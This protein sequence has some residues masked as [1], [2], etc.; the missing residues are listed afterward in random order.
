MDACSERPHRKS[1]ILKNMDDIA[2]KGLSN[3]SAL[4]F[5]G[6]WVGKIAYVQVVP[7]AASIKGSFTR[8][9]IFQRFCMG[10]SLEVMFLGHLDKK[11]GWNYIF[12]DKCC[13]HDWELHHPNKH[14]LYHSWTWTPKAQGEG[15]RLHD[16]I[17]LWTPK[18]SPTMKRTCVKI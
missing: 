9:P 7:Q 8:L 2:S 14:G 6:Y 11:L 4:E 12:V 3:L 13:E 10:S 5:V 1:S 18:R 15:V 16:K 17:N